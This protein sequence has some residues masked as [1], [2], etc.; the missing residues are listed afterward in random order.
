MLLLHPFLFFYNY[1]PLLRSPLFFFSI[2]QLILSLPWWTHDIG[3]ANQ[4]ISP[5]P[6]HSDSFTDTYRSM[7]FNAKTFHKLLRKKCS[8]SAK[9]AKETVASGC[10]YYHMGII[11]LRMKTPQG[12]TMMKS[13]TTYSWCYY[14]SG[15]RFS[16]ERLIFL[17]SPCHVVLLCCRPLSS[18]WLLI[19]SLP[20]NSVNTWYHFW[21]K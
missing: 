12:K 21:L 6:G 8:L 19:S 16:M 11:Y 13:K 2:L 5:H 10:L 18:S 15:S 4:S 1:T 17:A 3:L 9:Y 14:L 20:G 7:K